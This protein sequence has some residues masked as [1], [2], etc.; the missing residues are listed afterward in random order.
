MPKDM[1]TN[2]ERLLRLA[3]D[4][5]LFCL[6]AVVMGLMKA[7]L[8]YH[9]AE[10]SHFSFSGPFIHSFLENPGGLMDYAG[11]FLTQFCRFP[12]LGALILGILAILF[13]HL[14]EKGLGQGTHSLFLSL[15]PPFCVLLYV[16]GARYGVYTPGIYG[17]PFSQ[18]IG[19][20][21]T[22]GLYLLS[23][24]FIGKRW[25][26]FA[27]AGLLAV[28][29]P[30]LGFYALLAGMM[31]LLRSLRE[32]M[33]GRTVIPVVFACLILP[34][35]AANLGFLY[36]RIN[37]RYAFFGGLPYPNFLFCPTSIIPLAVAILGTLLV[38]I[39]SG[40]K[41]PVLAASGAAFAAAFAL[42][43]FSGKDR[44][45]DAQ[46]RMERAM[47]ASDWDQV[48]QIA[49][50]AENPNRILVLYR[51][52][53][54]YQQGEL[55]DRM[56]EYPDGSAPLLDSGGLPMSLTY[57]PELYLRTGLLNYAER[58]ATELSVSYIKCTRYLK[59][60]TRVAMLRGDI[61]LAEK[62][63]SVLAENPFLRPWTQKYSTLA[64]DPAGL[65]HDPDLARIAPLV[66]AGGPA[67]ISG[68]VA[69]SVIWH[70]FSTVPA[71]NLDL[72]QWKM[73]ALMT[74]KREAAFMDEFLSHVESCPDERIPKGIAQAA[75]LFGGTS[76]DRDL[77]LKIFGIFKDDTTLLREFS[78]FGK[79]YN[80]ASDVSSE[81]MRKRYRERYG[82]TYWFYY[83]F[84]ND[85][86]TN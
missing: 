60:L 37:L 62:Y 49:R 70:H 5:G 45:F 57:A 28:T 14:V 85:I 36:P 25:W 11:A 15:I 2:T 52:I 84:I 46:L 20:C 54:L 19:L 32:G 43:F 39:L 71:A 77:Y 27:L 3:I 21:S 67:F 31:V 79:S 86:Q 61:A 74:Q 80:A 64:R 65:S 33:V 4:A 18:I 75:V 69:E 12:F 8:L 48:L 42:V 40:R 30:V 34:L 63:L 51:D 82:T 10:Y 41:Y 1:K 23:G 72:Y 58:W 76:G 9:Y 29:Y 44:N 38:P 7:A 78:A 53:A 16:S 47:D 35:A 68:D 66:Q 13:R 22:L 56:F 24:R 6:V 26:G 50:S 83:Y 55:C 81:Y 73:A 17:I 59:V